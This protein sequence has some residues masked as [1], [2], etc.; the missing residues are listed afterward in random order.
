MPMC[1]RA[2]RLL[3]PPSWWCQSEAHTSPMSKICAPG[4]PLHRAALTATVSMNPSPFSE[5]R[6]T[7][8]TGCA[9]CS[10]WHRSVAEVGLGSGAVVQLHSAQDGTVIALLHPYAARVLEHAA[11]LRDALSSVPKPMVVSIVQVLAH[12]PHPGRPAGHTATRA[13]V[14]MQ[15][16]THLGVNAHGL[17]WLL[18]PI[19]T[20]RTLVTGKWLSIANSI[21]SCYARVTPALHP[22]ELGR[23]GEVQMSIDDTSIC[24]W[25]QH[26]ATVFHICIKKYTCHQN[27]DQWGRR[28]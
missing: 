11:Q 25:I 2:P 8:N 14:Q 23:A 18:S 12:V 17:F 6:G 16:P 4:S 15:R 27:T 28:N 20:D 22:I 9:S 7:N 1:Q 24:Q 19:S 13:P 21:R 26:G 10:S 5:S 3:T